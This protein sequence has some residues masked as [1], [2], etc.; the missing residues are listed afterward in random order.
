MTFYLTYLVLWALVALQGVILLGVVRTLYAVRSRGATDAVYQGD[1]A[2]AFRAATVRGESVE[3]S[4]WLGQ[5]TAFLFVSPNC[6]SCM[7]TLDELEALKTKAS[8]NV[9]V[10]CRG[11]HDECLELTMQHSLS[12]PVLIDEEYGIS[13]RF[14]ITETPTAVLV[15]ADGRIASTGQPDRSGRFGDS[16]ASELAANA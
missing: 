14:G 5:L 11:R 2:P 8:G 7:L 4:Q 6:A 3:S 15:N 9:V 12:I 10:I 1:E 16:L 13:E